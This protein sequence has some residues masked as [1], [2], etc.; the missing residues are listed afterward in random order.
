MYVAPA[1]F[2]HYFMFGYLLLKYSW[3]PF[4]PCF[5]ASIAR[6][7][8]AAPVTASPPANTPALGGLSVALASATMHFHLLVCSPSVVEEISGFGE[9]PRDMITVST[10]H[11]V[12]GAWD[13]YRSA[14]SGC[15]RLAKLHLHGPTMPVNPVILVGQDLYRVGQKVE[16]CTPSSF[17]W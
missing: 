15:I 2:V 16:D 1:L 8:V 11:G 13:L 4:A 7:T 5:P 14:A 12:V 6:I 3:I 10:S 9:V 17:A